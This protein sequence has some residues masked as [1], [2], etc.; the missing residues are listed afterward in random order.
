MSQTVLP[1]V[2]MAMEKSYE[3]LQYLLELSAI[4]DLT[5]IFDKYDDRIRSAGLTGS[6]YLSNILY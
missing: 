6:E 2:T 3:T 4:T 5:I 1:S